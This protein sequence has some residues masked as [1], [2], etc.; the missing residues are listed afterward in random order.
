MTAN[1]SLTPEDFNC[2]FLITDI[3]QNIHYTNDYFHTK[4][5]YENNAL[6]HAVLA[7]ILSAGSQIFNESYL[8]PL[9]LHEKQFEEIQLNIKDASGGKVPV[10]VS[11]V[12]HDEQK[13]YWSIFSSIQRDALYQELVETQRRLEDKA[14]ELQAQSATDELTGLLNRRELGRQYDVITTTAKRS[15]RPLSMLVMDI[16]HFKDINDQLGHT[17]GDTVLRQ[18]G[19]LFRKH[20]RESDVIARFGGDEFVLLL[21]DNTTAD[22]EA[23]AQRLHR[24]ISEL[25]I[26]GVSVTVSIGVASSERYLSFDE[27]FKQ[28]DYALYQAKA[29]GRDRTSAS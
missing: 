20:G 13:I 26:P 9:L 25:D 4:F 18:L 6:N 23:F 5:G 29:E 21:P 11:A 10:M 2:G 28:A 16:D 12:L 17:V 8:V 22:A 3:E 24:L 14:I 7:D 27:L 15:P 1:Q 19:E